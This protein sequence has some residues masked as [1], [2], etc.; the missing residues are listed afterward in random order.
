MKSE[1]CIAFTPLAPGIGQEVHGV[2]LC[3]P[4]S[5]DALRLVRHALVNHSVL[6]FREQQ[7]L[8]PRGLVAFSAR[9]GRLEQHLLSDFLLPDQPEVFVV[10]NIVEDGRPDGAHGGTQWWHSDLSYMPEPS[11]GSV[12]HCLECPTVGGDTEFASMY[13]AWEALEPQRQK[14]L[15]SQRG[16]HDYAWHYAKYLHQRSPLTGAQKARV[17][18]VTHPCVR[19]HPETGR[20]ALYLGNTLVRRFAGK[21]ERESQGLLNEINDFATSARFCYRHRWRPGDV[22]FWDNR[23]MVHRACSFDDTRERRRMHRT[24]IRGDRPYIST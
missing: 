7:A 24:T 3:E 4:L 15:L 18:P 19:T 11:L 13:S 23:S 9:F 21:S 20:R 17:P 1:P 5:E 8:S 2:D 22:V 10:S 12:F 6:L 16:V 14:W